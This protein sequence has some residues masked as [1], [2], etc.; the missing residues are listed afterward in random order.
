MPFTRDTR[1]PFINIEFNTSWVVEFVEDF[2]YKLIGSD[3]DLNIYVE[4]LETA[5][6]FAYINNTK[7]CVHEWLMDNYN[8]VEHWNYTFEKVRSC[9]HC[10]EVEED[11]IGREFEE[12]D[13]G[14]LCCE[15]CIK[16][17]DN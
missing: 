7:L 10:G 12:D 11:Y 14:Y 8:N 15:D 2:Q 1:C 9:D 5:F 13:N 6:M 17:C 3:K 4:E 16:D